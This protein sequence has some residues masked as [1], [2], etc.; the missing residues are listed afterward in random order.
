VRGLFLLAFDTDGNGTIS[1]DELRDSVKTL[2]DIRTNA[3][4][5]NYT[6]LPKEVQDVLSVFDGDKSGTVD[7]AELAL[8]A[9]LYSASKARN[10]K[11]TKVVIG[12]SLLILVIMAALTGLMF[13]VV[14]MSK[15]TKA[16]ADGTITV[17]GSNV[18]VK[19][20]NP[21]FTTA[22]STKDAGT[23][24]RRRS[25]LSEDGSQSATTLVD[26]NGVPI[27]TGVLTDGTTG[28][29]KVSEA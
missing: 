17:A 14:E 21:G 3:A 23:D 29:Q 12:L 28:T 26:A 13:A 20:D 4:S 16:S 9:Q 6:Q 11:L 15:E 22:T 27:V 8:G 24:G 25:L 1:I 18:T 7:T 19:T 10:R 2:R 5:I